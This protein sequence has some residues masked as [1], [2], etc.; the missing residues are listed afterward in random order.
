MHP[1]RLFIQQVITLIPKAFECYGIRSTSAP[2]AALIPTLRSSMIDKRLHVEDLIAALGSA[3]SQ[4]EV[5]KHLQRY[6][7]SLGF[8]HCTYDLMLAP[9]GQQQTH[10]TNFPQDFVDHYIANRYARFDL[11]ANYAATT[12]LPFSWTDVIQKLNPGKD[13][14]AIRNEATEFGL[15][16]VAMV[17]IHGPANTKA[18]LALANNMN[19]KEFEVLFSEWKHV[20]QI[21]AAHLHERILD[22]N[23]S[24]ESNLR[25]LLTAR[26]LE[27]LTW[28]ASGKS[29]PVTA[30]ILEIKES[31]VKDHLKNIFSKLGVGSKEQAIAKA[32]EYGLIAR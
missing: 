3:M 23:S 21:I 20:L 2:T 6:V 5:A 26:E 13:H 17:P 9:T 4:D 14:Y 24:R 25:G 7:N 31:T 10:F 15:R 29:Y 11:M 1:Y 28:S 32:V 16:N 27:I 8:N 12:L 30:Q 19:P 22:F 18:Y